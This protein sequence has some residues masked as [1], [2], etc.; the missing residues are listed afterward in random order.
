MFKTRKALRRLVTVAALTFVLP[1]A[2]AA[3]GH[4]EGPTTS[5]DHDVEVHIHGTPG[6][7]YAYIVID[8]GTG[9]ATSITSSSGATGNVAVGPGGVGIAYDVAVTSDDTYVEIGMGGTSAAPKHLAKKLIS[10]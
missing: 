5:F 2:F 1:A 6:H 4:S 8:H 10:P 9:V 7:W 3:C